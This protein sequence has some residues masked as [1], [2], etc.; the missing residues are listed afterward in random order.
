M[1]NFFNHTEYQ[2]VPARI[3]GSPFVFLVAMDITGY[4]AVTVE[5]E[6]KAGKA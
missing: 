4:Q 1:T 3:T 5:M 2:H 6:L